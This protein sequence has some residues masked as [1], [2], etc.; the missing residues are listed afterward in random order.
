MLPLCFA[1]PKFKLNWSHQTQKLTFKLHILFRNGLFCLSGSKLVQVVKELPTHSAFFKYWHKAFISEV[2]IPNTPSVCNLP[3]H[4]DTSQWHQ[5]QNRHMKWINIIAIKD[6][7]GPENLCWRRG[8]NWR[9]CAPL[10]SALSNS[11]VLH[12]SGWSSTLVKWLSGRSTL[13]RSPFFIARGQTQHLKGYIHPNN[14]G[15][16]ARLTARCFHV[17]FIFSILRDFLVKVLRLGSVYLNIYRA[18]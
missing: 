7:K 2:K 6:E 17:W 16:T 3:H 8:L 14:T 13:R 9:P 18:R 11:S 5:R 15:P 10:L 12:S 1:A 4:S